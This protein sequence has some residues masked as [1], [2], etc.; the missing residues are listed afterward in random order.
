MYDV[1]TFR[2]R[3]A[4]RYVKD[5]EIPTRVACK[6]V[7]DPEAGRAT[8]IHSHHNGKSAFNYSSVVSRSPINKKLASERVVFFFFF[9]SFPP[10][11]GQA[12]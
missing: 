2:I 7:Y 6:Q 10:L 3:V 12:L 5:W 8:Y 11:G 4:W 1:Y 9:F